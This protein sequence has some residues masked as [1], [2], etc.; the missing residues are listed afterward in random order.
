METFIL[1]VIF[2]AIG[3]ILFISIYYYINNR[4]LSELELQIFFM[5][6]EKL[7]QLR[8]FAY[9]L[10]KNAC[11]T[12][13]VFFFEV[14]DI[15]I[16]KDCDNENNKSVGLYTH[17]KNKTLEEMHK[18]T[19]ENVKDW[20]ELRNVFD[21]YNLYFPKI[22]INTESEYYKEFAICYTLAH[23][24]GHHLIKINN[25]EQSEELANKYVYNVFQKYLPKCFLAISNTMLG[26]YLETNDNVV[27]NFN[28]YY[29]DYKI[30]RENYPELNLPL[31]EN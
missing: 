2:L 22:Q 26:I 18:L 16:N 8:D 14:P 11:N 24:L 7:P 4:K 28:E 27:K 10:L 20:N 9:S 12:E 15:I 30:F 17:M 23:E 25:E 13:G 6:L 19:K 1:V 21:S 3:F 5:K 31:M 29:K